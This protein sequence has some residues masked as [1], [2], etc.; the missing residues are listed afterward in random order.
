MPLAINNWLL[1]VCSSDHKGNSFAFRPGKGPEQLS[2]YCV[3][4]AVLCDAALR[5]QSSSEPLVE[6]FFPLELTWVLFPLP[7]KKTSG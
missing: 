5:V 1:F 4:L 2:R 6:G 7:R 3:G